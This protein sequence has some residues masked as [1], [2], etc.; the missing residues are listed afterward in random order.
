MQDAFIMKSA[1][2]V[3]EFMHDCLAT[4]VYHHE[5]FIDAIAPYKLMYQTPLHSLT[6]KETMNMLS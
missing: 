6:Y 5:I 4:L 3:Q 1:E 2:I